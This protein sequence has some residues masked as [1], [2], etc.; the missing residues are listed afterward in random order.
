MGERGGGVSPG[1]YYF[2]YLFFNF[3]FNKVNRPRWKAGKVDKVFVV[4]V[5]LGHFL[6][7]ILPF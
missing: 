6:R 2:F 5:I 3:F 4:V 7:H 1:V